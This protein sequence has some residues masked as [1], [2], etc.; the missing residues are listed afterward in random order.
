MAA[1]PN[2]YLLRSWGHGGF[3]G[4][5]DDNKAASEVLEL[6]PEAG[7]EGPWGLSK[8]LVLRWCMSPPQPK[9][10]APNSVFCLYLIMGGGRLLRNQ[11]SQSLRLSGLSLSAGM[12]LPGK[13][14]YLVGPGVC[15]HT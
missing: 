10:V 1:L 15:L 5:E 8:T 4:G 13:R 3:L 11:V 6:L 9:T 7:G 12:L 2:S 14:S